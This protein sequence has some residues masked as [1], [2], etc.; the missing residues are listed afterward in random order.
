MS[1]VVGRYVPL[2]GR[3][4]YREACVRVYVRGTTCRCMQARIGYCSKCK[5]LLSLVVTYRT[6]LVARTRSIG[7]R[8]NCFRPLQYHDAVACRLITWLPRDKVP[9]RDP[10]STK[11]QIV[12]RWELIATILGG[13]ISRGSWRTR[14]KGFDNESWV[15]TYSFW[16]L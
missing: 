5:L 7:P 12:N 10:R 13:A 8:N 4:R 3:K 14:D 6:G 15:L 1:R 9:V 2:R 16:V 11:L